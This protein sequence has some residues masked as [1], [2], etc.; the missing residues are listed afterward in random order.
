MSARFQVSQGFGALSSGVSQS[1]GPAPSPRPAVAAARG[2]YHEH[3]RHPPADG[4]YPGVRRLFGRKSRH[5]QHKSPFPGTR[6]RQ[7]C[8]NAENSENWSTSAKTAEAARTPASTKDRR[9][10][11][12]TQDPNRTKKYHVVPARM[13]VSVRSISSL[14]IVH[15]GKPAERR[16]SVNRSRNSGLAVSRLYR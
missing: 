1:F 6:A 5:L 10:F 14:V 8:P 12:H 15:S 11:L 16:P 3:H 7:G 2:P 4:R 13:M 9:A